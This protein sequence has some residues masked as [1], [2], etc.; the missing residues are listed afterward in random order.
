MKSVITDYYK[1][2]YSNNF[3]NLDEMDKF[4]KRYKLTKLMQEELDNLNSTVFIKEME[5]LV[6]SLPTNKTLGL[7]GFTGEI[8]QTSKE[9][10]TPILYTLSES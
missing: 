9:D 10:I 3:D 7:A 5:F 6:K 4:F 8:H 1:Q 2:L